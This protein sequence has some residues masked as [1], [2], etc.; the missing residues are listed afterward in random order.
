MLPYFKTVKFNYRP[1]ITELVPATK[2]VNIINNNILIQP[3]KY[4]FNYPDKGGQIRKIA[5]SGGMQFQVESWMV[6][7][8]IPSLKFKF[9]SNSTA[10][11]PY[12]NVNMINNTSL[13]VHEIDSFNNIVETYNITFSPTTVPIS[14]EELKCSE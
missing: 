13:T 10:I 3:E 2:I 8:D 5:L 7:T 6:E 4:Y 12:E 1:T 9:T 11:P 14:I